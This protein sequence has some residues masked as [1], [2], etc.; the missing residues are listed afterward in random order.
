MIVNMNRTVGGRRVEQ[1]KHHGDEVY[2]DRELKGKY[3][4]H[5]LCHQCWRFTP[6]PP[7]FRVRLVVWLYRVL[8]K[9][10]F[11]GEPCARARL[12]FAYCIA[13]NMVTPVY[14]CGEMDPLYVMPL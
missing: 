3:R 2:V 12:L 7:S 6:D 5:C 8:A 4:E 9:T 10:L 11:R 14:E 13:F 1:Y